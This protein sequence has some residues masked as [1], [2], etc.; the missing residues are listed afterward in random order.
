MDFRVLELAGTLAVT[1]MKL[2]RHWGLGCSVRCSLKVSLMV[3]SGLEV[4]GGF[5]AL[6]DAIPHDIHP[7]AE[8][9]QSRWFA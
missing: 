1:N 5:K 9:P 4:G 6:G 7:R 2:G 3:C 8:I